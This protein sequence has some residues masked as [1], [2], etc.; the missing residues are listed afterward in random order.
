[1]ESDKGLPKVLAMLEDDGLK[2]KVEAAIDMTSGSERRWD[3]LTSL[4]KWIVVLKAELFSVVSSKIDEL[5]LRIF[6]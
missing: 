2:R 1:M 4:V 3:K 6:C 5:N